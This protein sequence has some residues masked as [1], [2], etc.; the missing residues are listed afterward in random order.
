[1]PAPVLDRVHR[2]HR[3]LVARNVPIC[4][5]RRYD[6]PALG[7][8]QAHGP[9][10]LPALRDPRAKRAEERK[11]MATETTGGLSS[12]NGRVFGGT[13]ET[14][15]ATPRIQPAPATLEEARNQPGRREKIEAITRR[16]EA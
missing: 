8:R 10:R 5:K 16:I 14:V 7:R 2:G 1:M 3:T 9:A 6:P 12:V 11:A 15:L 4:S 13:V